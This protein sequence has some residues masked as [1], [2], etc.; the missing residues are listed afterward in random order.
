ME[1]D[2]ISSEMSAAVASADENNASTT[3]VGS[4]CKSSNS[5]TPEQQKDFDWCY[6]TLENHK[7]SIPNVAKAIAKIDREKYYENDVD[8]E[9]CDYK[10]ADDFIHEIFGFERT[11]IYRMK[12]F[13]S[14]LLK[15]DFPEGHEPSETS[16]RGMFQNGYTDDDREKIYRKAQ[17][18]CFNRRKK[19]AKNSP[20]SSCSDEMSESSGG[21]D[22][23]SGDG[24]G[25]DSGESPTTSDFEDEILQIVPEAKDIRKAIEDFKADSDRIYFPQLDNKSYPKDTAFSVILKENAEKFTTT[26][27]VLECFKLYKAETDMTVVDEE[28]EQSIRELIR[29]LI[30]ETEAEMN[31]LLQNSG[32]ITENNEN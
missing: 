12:K 31:K 9:D 16:V 6:E 26:G 20:A 29:K 4:E 17:E 3:K 15:K 30:R 28:T 27:I 22:S 7:R 23:M 25:C 24:Q 10:N 18:N 19:G 5:L 13:G 21:G 1:T 32:A 14:W 11:Y 8:F 2:S